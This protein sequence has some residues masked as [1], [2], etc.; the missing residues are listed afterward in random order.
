MPLALELECNIESPGLSWIPETDASVS[1]SAPVPDVNHLND[2]L[3]FQN[4]VND[5]VDVRLG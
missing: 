5:P 4:P 3:F 2:F 1:P